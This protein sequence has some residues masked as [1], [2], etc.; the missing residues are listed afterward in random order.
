MEFSDL[1]DTELLSQL[2]TLT[3]Q[4]RVIL[5]HLLATLGEVEERRLHLEAACSSLFDYCVQ[6]L[7]MSEGEA[8]RRIT[9]ARLA[10]RFPAILECIERGELHL[11]AVVL[12]RD[13]LT[14]ENHRELLRAASGKT[15]RK[16][17]EML[18]ARFPRPDASPRIR[19]LPTRAA[20]IE[21]LS[22]DRYRVQFTASAELRR[23][24]ERAADLMRHRNPTGELAAIVER[25][26][27]LLIS[28]LEKERLGKTGRAAKKPMPR[29][30]RPGYVTKAVRRE[31]F[32]RDGEQC[33]FVDREGR[34]CSSRAF[35]ELDH[36]HPRA[37]GGSGETKNIRVLCR[38]HNRRMAERAFGR[39]HVD[40]KIH[41][42]QRKCGAPRATE[43][44]GEASRTATQRSPP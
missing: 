6:R 24:L 33:S 8:F 37:L 34:R 43:C 40:R 30:T 36:A 39:E 15:R 27:D 1:S 7:G 31:A 11:S 32:E 9:A 44:G 23:K 18:A 38:A 20:G 29:A 13:H 28:Q 17:Q 4:Q 3:G 35:L 12:L 26:L 41:L 16:V 14:V 5:A 19:A 42:R 22:A 21:P 25:G 2:V 10:R